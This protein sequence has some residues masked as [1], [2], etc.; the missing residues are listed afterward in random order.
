MVQA[1]A[2]GARHIELAHPNAAGLSI[3]GS[4]FRFAGA[5]LSRKS[6]RVDFGCMPS[7]KGIA[8]PNSTIQQLEL[9]L[10]PIIEKDVAGS[11]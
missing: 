9:E 4:E 11:R 6:Y 2:G 5:C 8:R 10:R 3:P 7:W 1:T